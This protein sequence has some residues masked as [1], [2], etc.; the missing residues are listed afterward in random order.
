VRTGR[1]A[2]MALLCIAASLSGCTT[3]DKTVPDTTGAVAG[4]ALPPDT[5]GTPHGALPSGWESKN[6]EEFRAY[7]DSVTWTDPVAGERTCADPKQCKKVQATISANADARRIT[8]NNAGNGTLMARMELKGP[9]ATLMYNLKPGAFKYYVVVLPSAGGGDMSWKLIQ[10]ADNGKTA[11]NE[12]GSGTFVDC[13]H[14]PN[15]SAPAQ[16][17]WRGCDDAHLKSAVQRMDSGGSGGGDQP[18]WVS[19]SEG[20]CTVSMAQ[21]T[22]GSVDAMYAAAEKKSGKASPRN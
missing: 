11:I 5:A 20:C 1:I 14:A 4:A 17:D 9:Y 12:I 3:K 13:K 2:P 22:L 8:K 19:C 18:G 21:M 7:A 15:P 6:S 10:V 16:A